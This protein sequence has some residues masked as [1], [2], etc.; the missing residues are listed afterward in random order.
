MNPSLLHRRSVQKSEDRLHAL[1][2]HLF[3]VY[4]DMENAELHGQG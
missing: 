3:L 1:T 2:T 4:G